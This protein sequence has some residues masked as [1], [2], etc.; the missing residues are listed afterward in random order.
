MLRDEG[1]LRR[2]VTTFFTFSIHHQNILDQTA[3]Y[4]SALTQP[5]AL[6]I[7]YSLNFQ[8]FTCPKQTDI[9]HGRYRSKSNETLV[10][11]HLSPLDFYVALKHPDGFTLPHNLVREPILWEMSVI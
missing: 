8:L 9:H 10:I 6:Y 2:P 11:S 5:L 7:K 4:W 1:A 3:Y